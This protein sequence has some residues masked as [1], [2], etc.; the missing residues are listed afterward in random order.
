[1]VTNPIINLSVGSGAGINPSGFAFQLSVPVGNT[2]VIPAST[3]M[4][5]WT[6]IYTNVALTASVVPTDA[7]AT[8]D[9]ARFYRALVQLTPVPESAAIAP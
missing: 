2:Y 7:A 6:P 3:N 4:Q 1:V 9:G 8:D 5:H